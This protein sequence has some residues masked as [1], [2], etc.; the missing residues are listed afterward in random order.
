MIV[1]RDPWSES[2]ADVDS[3]IPWAKRLYASGATSGDVRR[4]D[5]GRPGGEQ[6]ARD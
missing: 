6:T 4:L 3:L 1:I 2:R 5:D